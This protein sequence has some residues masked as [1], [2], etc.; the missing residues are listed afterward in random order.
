MFTQCIKMPLFTSRAGQTHLT[1]AVNMVGHVE[2]TK[3]HIVHNFEAI[4]GLADVSGR[5]I[6]TQKTKSNRVQECESATM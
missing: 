2:D 6:C 4:T 3:G 1:I 5:K